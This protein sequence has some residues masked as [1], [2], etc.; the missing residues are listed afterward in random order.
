MVYQPSKDLADSQRLKVIYRQ[1]VISLKF[2][3]SETISQ[4]PRDV[5]LQAINEVWES[6]EIGSNQRPIA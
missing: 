2:H 4:L 1:L 6:S 5:V 3:H